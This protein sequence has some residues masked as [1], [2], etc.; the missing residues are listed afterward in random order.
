MIKA[1]IFDVGGV[2][3][4]TVDRTPR[5]NLEQRLGLAP[6]AADILYFNGDMGQ[7][8]QRGLISTAELLAWIQAELKLDDSG[9]EAFRREFW[10]GDQLDG[11]LLDLVRS[12]RPHYTTAILSNWA[13]NLVPMIS[14]EY[15]LADAFDLII[16]SA[17]EGI[18]KPDAAIFERAL[19][20][21]GVAPHEAV[22]IDDF[23]HNIAGAEAVGLRGIHYQAGMNLAAALAKVGAFIPTA[24][25]DRFSIEPMPRSALPALADM[26]NECSMALK[27]ENS[28]LLEEMESE[29]NRPGMEPARDMFLVTERATGRIA[30][31]A[32]CWNES[33]PHVETY[34]FGRVHPDFRDLGLG[35]RLLGLAEA[36]AWEK[37]ALAPPDAEVFIM[38]ATDLLATDAVQL[39]TD[40]GYSQNRLFQRMLIDLDELPSAPEF[41]DGIRVRTY[42]PE[43]FEMVVRAHKEAFS[44]HWGFPDTPLEDYIGRWQTV[45][46]DANFDPSCWF[47]AM[48]GDELAGFSLC[49]PVMAESPD[50]GLVDDLGVRRPWRRR[51]LGLTLLKHSF[52]ELYQKGKRKVRLGVDSSSLT[53]ATALYQ[54][55]GMRVITETAV[56]RK[57]LRPGVDL[58][59]Q[60]AAE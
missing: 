19:E 33:P 25:D 59:T 12:L 37:L 40:H 11:A 49:W 6:G 35:S 43:D 46:D 3:I 34:V 41:P 56:Y 10:A 26:L 48:D 50:M 22:F 55:A 39:F 4:R 5:A 28:I 1:I 54:R 8:A 32:E 17:N 30:A 57:I 31:Y 24:L 7:K 27:G 14:E 18:V 20:K 23:A 58:H 13:D 2:L 38:V 42:R 47:L 52:R 44:D 45:V 60:G 36:R 21:L 53:N 29:F 16:G 51:G 9:I 15:P